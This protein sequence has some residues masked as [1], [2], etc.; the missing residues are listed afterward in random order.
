MSPAR[1]RIARLARRSLAA[2]LAAPLWALAQCL[3]PAPT[4]LLERFIPAEC[5][6]CWSEGAA[7]AGAPFVL[8]WIVPSALGDDA[9]LSAAAVAEAGP[10]AGALA[11]TRTLERVQALDAAPAGLAVEVEDGPGWAGYVGL[12]LR[13]RQ[14]AGA[15]LAADAAG[16]LA[17]VE[18]VAAGD[19]GTPVARRLVRVL[20]GPLPLDA[21]RPVLEH[22]LALRLRQGARL[23]RLGAVGWVESAPGRVIAIAAAPKG[24]CS[25]AAR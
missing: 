18:D 2:A 11:V 4:V 5:A 17:L 19:E 3:A 13:V 10:R 8:D 9:A 22:L 16:Y 6:A 7:P 20:A 1:A 14:A 12:L 15:A 24:D 25:A 23:E 21:A